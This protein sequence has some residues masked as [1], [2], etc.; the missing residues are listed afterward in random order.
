MDE[1]PL[2]DSIA[3]A[4]EGP[5]ELESLPTDPLILFRR[6]FERAEASG[7]RLPNA[8]ALATADIDARPSVRHV[9]LRGVT[10]DGFVFYTNHGSRK[11][12]E[13]AQNPRAA[14]SI[15]WR[16]LDRQVNVLGDVERVGEEESDAYFA[17]RPRE[18]RLGAW[19]S[20]Q[21]SELASREELMERFAEFDAEYPGED[22]PRPSFWGGYLVRPNAIEFWQGRQHRLHDRFRYDR[23]GDAW[24]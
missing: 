3:G 8:I 22:V 12:R 4:T 1:R 11:G 7:I 6:W 20:R 14:F 18:A 5:L 16:E 21:S 2:D 9:L 17:T 24:R 13:L 19:A 10:D 23:D 15:Y